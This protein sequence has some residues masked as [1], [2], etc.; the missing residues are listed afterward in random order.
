M[1]NRLVDLKEVEFAE[2][3]FVRDIENH[4]F[5][6][7]IFQCLAKIDGISLQESGIIDTLLGAAE[8]C[9]GIIV[10]QDQKKH[11]VFVR[12]E[13]NIRYGVPIPQKAEEIQNKIVEEICNFTGLHVSCVHV[14]F[15]NLIS[16]PKIEKQQMLL[17]NQPTSVEEFSE[18]F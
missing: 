1:D 8:K 3:T 13:V 18:T 5:K 2:T 7:I 15:K 17:N 14:V 11:S 6:S 4:V 9:R 10:E 12:V 16:E